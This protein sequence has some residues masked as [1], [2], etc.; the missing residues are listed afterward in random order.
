MGDARLRH[1]P[2]ARSGDRRPAQ[3]GARPRRRDRDRARRRQHLPRP[4]AAPRRAWTA[5]PADYMGMLAIVLNA[6]TLQDALEKRGVHT[7]V[8]SA[9]TISEVAE[10]YIRRRA[11]R[12]LEKDRIVI[13]AAGTG[14]PFFTSDTAAALRAL[15]M[16]AEVLLMAKNGV[17]GIYTADPR[18]DPDAEFIP[19]IT[20]ARGAA[21]RPEG[22][23]LRRR[24]RCAWTTTSPIH[25]FNMDDESQHQPDNL[26]RASG[27][28]GDDDDRRTPPGRARAHG[29]VRGGDAQQVRL[30]PRP[31]RASPALLDRINVDYYGAQTP[32]Q[33][34]GDDQRARGAAADRPAVRQELDQGDRAGD[35]GVRPRPDAEQRRRDHPPADP[36]ADRGAAQAA[37]QGRA[38]AR[39]GGQGGDPQH[40]P[41]RHARPAR[42]CK[43]AGEA[44]ADDEHRAEEA[45]QKLTDEKVNEL[46]ALLKGKEAE[47]LE[48]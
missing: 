46:D 35:P 13:F 6:L 43:D 9:I 40:P 15:E 26:R 45:L 44:G 12:H 38:R 18:K 28:A 24:C 17:E 19:E 5:R 14:N 1:R 11:M 7:R 25:V 37:R 41:R 42:S 29:Q 47:I 30:G 3:G 2:G 48:V 22:D 33:A 16:H 8:Q 34:A 20:R 36:R 32:L 27:D 39:R 10:P 4:R 31:G 21:A 23:G